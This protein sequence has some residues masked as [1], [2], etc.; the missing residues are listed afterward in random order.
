MANM[1]QSQSSL[2]TK[3]PP[4]L[5]VM[6]WDNALDTKTLH[7]ECVDNRFQS[8]WCNDTKDSTKLGF[9]HACWNAHRFISRE[10]RP[11]AKNSSTAQ[12][13]GPGHWYFLLTRFISREERRPIAREFLTAHEPRRGRLCFLLTCKTLYVQDRTT[14]LWMRERRPTLTEKGQLPRG[15]R[16][17]ISAYHFCREEDACNPRAASNVTRYFLA[18]CASIASEYGLPVSY[19]RHHHHHHN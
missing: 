8:V 5:R 3:I 11:M 10:R 15:A 4:E 18:S 16:Y 14:R 1:E 12:G 13:Q 9:R 17:A 19:R 7:F 6:I 2:L